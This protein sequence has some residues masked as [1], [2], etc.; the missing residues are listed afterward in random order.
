MGYVSGAVTLEEA[1]RRADAARERAVE[2]VRR[3]IS[4]P[5]TGP[6]LRAKLERALARQQGWRAA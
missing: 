1:R 2:A 5:R 3:M 6:V 4:D